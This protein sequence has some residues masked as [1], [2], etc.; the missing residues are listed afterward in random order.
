MNSVDQVKLII[1]H[2]C[3]EQNRQQ[4][5]KEK[6]D[7]LET[8]R[9]VVAL[10]V[11]DEIHTL[12]DKKDGFDLKTCIESILLKTFR[13]KQDDHSFKFLYELSCKVYNNPTKYEE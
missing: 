7:E 1:R 3:M 8:T 6:W 13:I 12:W 4:L 2:A 11:S 5:Y 9:I 10:A